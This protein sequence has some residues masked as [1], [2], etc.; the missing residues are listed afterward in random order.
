MLNIQRT[1]N[2]G[3]FALVL[4]TYTRDGQTTDYIKA[5]PSLSSKRKVRVTCEAKSLSGISHV[6]D[7]VLRDKG[8]YDWLNTKTFTLN[9]QS[10]TT[11]EAYLVVSPDKD[12]YLKIYD[13]D[14][15]KIPSSI[16]IQNLKVMEVI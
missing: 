14:V 4:N 9:A 3:R 5:D 2:E 11:L 1:D 12:F 6:L 8:S 16:Q 15:A 13:H 7:F 10:W